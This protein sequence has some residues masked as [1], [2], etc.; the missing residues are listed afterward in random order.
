MYVVGVDSKVSDVD[1][2]PYS[3]L[4]YGNGPGY[5]VPRT[6]PPNRT[7]PYPHSMHGP[8]SLKGMPLTEDEEVRMDGMGLR[9]S[10]RCCQVI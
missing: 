1:G 9:R 5:S 2:M 4:L 7:R 10:K 8:G 3:T 6:V